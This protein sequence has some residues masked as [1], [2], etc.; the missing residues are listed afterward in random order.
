MSDFRYSLTSTQVDVDAQTPCPTVAK[1]SSRMGPVR[2][3]IAPR[4]KF[5]VRVYAVTNHEAWEDWNLLLFAEPKPPAFND[6]AKWGDALELKL[7][8]LQLLH[9]KVS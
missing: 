1:L 4:Y 5:E 3:G 7:E 8:F 9:G 6:L 2:V